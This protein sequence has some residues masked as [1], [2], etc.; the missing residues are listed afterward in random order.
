MELVIVPVLQLVILAAVPA[1][2]ARVS[3][4]GGGTPGIK[5]KEQH[6]IMTDFL[7]LHIP[8]EPKLLTQL[9]HDK[10]NTNKSIYE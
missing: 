7:L 4:N 2:R 10:I 5:R 9:Y 1:D 6:R 3:E 8:L